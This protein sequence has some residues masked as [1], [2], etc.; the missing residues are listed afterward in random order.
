MHARTR[1]ALKIH[2]IAIVS[3]PTIQAT[4]HDKSIRWY[5]ALYIHLVVFLCTA[6]TSLTRRSTDGILSNP[7]AQTTTAVKI[8]ISSPRATRIGS[9]HF[10]VFFSRMLV[11]DLRRFAA[12]KWNVKEY[13]YDPR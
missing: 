13:P 10:D 7:T 8:A 5:H 11:T 6:L 12:R 4:L 9:L 1:V 3:V 2:W